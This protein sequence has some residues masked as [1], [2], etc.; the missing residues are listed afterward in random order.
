MSGDF[1][2]ANL[3]IR[4]TLQ[5]VSQTISTLSQAGESDR[6]ELQRLIKQLIDTLQAA[7]PD[8]SPQAEEVSEATKLFVEAAAE[9]KPNQTMVKMLGSGL[10]QAAQTLKAELP[11]VLDITA[12]IVSVVSAIAALPA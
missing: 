9:P 10:K 4:S 2:D 3:T 12:K 11:A 1:R 5:D 8:K 6:G 7:P